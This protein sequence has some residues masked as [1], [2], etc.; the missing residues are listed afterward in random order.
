MEE[1]LK[2]SIIAIISVILALILTEKTPFFAV[3]IVLAVSVIILGMCFAQL[4]V[5][6]KNIEDLIS[7]SKISMDIFQPVIKVCAIAIIVKIA[8]DI[9]KDSGYS[10]ISQK[11]QFAGSISSIIAV[12]PLFLKI[13]QLLQDII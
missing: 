10:S 1:I 6:L 11:I 9:C 4:E 12:F 13:I 3:C 5:L 2:I 7:S 8:G